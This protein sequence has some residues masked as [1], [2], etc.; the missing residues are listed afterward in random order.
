MKLTFL[1]TGNVF[2]LAV[3]RFMEYNGERFKALRRKILDE[4]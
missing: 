4:R 1:V 2:F 3:R